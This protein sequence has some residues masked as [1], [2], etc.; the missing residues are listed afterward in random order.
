MRR[1][2]SFRLFVYIFDFIWINSMYSVEENI[3]TYTPSAVASKGTP[4]R[5]SKYIN[6]AVSS[7]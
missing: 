3:Q 2:C 6:E 7:N 1:D 4:V 5:S